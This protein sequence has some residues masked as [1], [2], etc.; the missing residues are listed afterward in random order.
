M[1]I[2][3]KKMYRLPEIEEKIISLIMTNRYRILAFTLAFVMLNL[4]PSLPYLNLF[5]GRSLIFFLIFSFFIV[6]FNLDIKI[7]LFIVFFFFLLSL[8][9]YLIGE[10]EAAEL[11]GNY[12]YGFLFTGVVLYTLKSTKR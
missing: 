1:R 11:L 8:G 2:S 7:I 12:I 4:L 5:I 6:I 10:V 9:L 3:N